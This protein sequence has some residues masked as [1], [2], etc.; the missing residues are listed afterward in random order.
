[1]RP[2]VGRAWPEFPLHLPPRRAGARLTYQG[3]P[4]SSIATEIFF[5]LLCFF[6]KSPPVL[7]VNEDC[8]QDAETH[9]GSPL[10]LLTFSSWRE[11]S[12]RVRLRHPAETDEINFL[13]KQPSPGFVRWETQTRASARVP[14][15]RTSRLCR[16]CLIVAPEPLA[17]CFVNMHVDGGREGSSRRPHRE[18]IQETDGGITERSRNLEQENWVFS[19]IV[20]FQQDGANPI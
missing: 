14:F 4:A 3:W 2:I 8:A 16:E 17:V 6:L 7:N 12:E 20:V 9:A 18:Q 11:E 15:P 1:M 19:V 5:F 13:C 10:C